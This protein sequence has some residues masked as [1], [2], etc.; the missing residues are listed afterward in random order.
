MQLGA[1]ALRADPLYEISTP[2]LHALARESHETASLGVLAGDNEVVYLQQVNSSANR[3][4]TVDWIGRTI[5]RSGTALGA[6]VNGNV[7]EGGYAV[8]K[9]EGSDVTAVAAPISD[10]NGIIGALSINAPSY[11][12]TTADT[13]TFGELLVAHAREI[14]LLLGGI[15]PLSAPAGEK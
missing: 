8:S 15:A 14:S 3:V 13:E 9:R 4:Q 7:R 10:R 5:P 2:H 11:R 6:A 1:M 12:V